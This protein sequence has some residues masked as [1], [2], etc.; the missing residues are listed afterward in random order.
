MMNR[1]L[2]CSAAALLAALPARA[3]QAPG[4]GMPSQ[5]QPQAPSNPG[6]QG[7]GGYPGTAA[8]PQ[9]AGDQEFVSKALQGGDIEVQLGQLAQQKSQSQD[10]KQ[11]GQKMVQDHSQ[12]GDKWFKPL[13]KQ[14]GVSEPKGPSKKDK[15]LIAKLEGLSGND[16]DTEYIK[17][18]VKD[19]QDDLKD[20]QSETQMAQDPNVKQVAQQ[21]QNV[22]SQHLQ[23][24]EQVAKNHNV[25][26]EGKEISS[27][28]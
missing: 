25:P 28:K 16:F 15:K 9:Q 13:A 7:P 21:G 22:I 6:M 26:V 1:I 24:I 10:V 14:L 2:I 27:T 19:H 17:A 8:T 4:G 23:M 5:Q 11:F 18:M 12:M 20:F 3:Q